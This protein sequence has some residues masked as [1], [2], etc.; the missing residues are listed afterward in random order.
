MA[1]KLYQ[2]QKESLTPKDR[3]IRCVKRIVLG[4][5]AA[6]AVFAGLWYCGFIHKTVLSK[7]YSPVTVEMQMPRSLYDNLDLPARAFFFENDG[8]KIPEVKGTRR[9]FVEQGKAFYEKLTFW[10]SRLISSRPAGKNKTYSMRPV[11]LKK[12]SYRVKVVVGPYVWW[13]SFSAGDEDVLITCDFLKNM[14]RKLT[15]KTYAA[16]SMSGEDITDKVQFKILYK[17]KWVPVS[18]IEEDSLE[19]GTVWKIRSECEGYKGEEFSLLI[20]W[21]QDELIISSELMPEEK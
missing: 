8:D 20:D 5:A 14:K 17:N 7:W 16:D 1:Q 6:A 12:G 18:E 10:N 2:Y 13:K 21:Y 4:V 11:F 3:F 19:S 9:T 15:V